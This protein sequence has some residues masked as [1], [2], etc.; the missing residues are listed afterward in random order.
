M[1]EHGTYPHHAVFLPPK[2]GNIRFVFDAAALHHGVSLNSQLLQGTDITNNL[3][4]GNST[5]V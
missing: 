3:L 2:L 5:E 4:G 1:G